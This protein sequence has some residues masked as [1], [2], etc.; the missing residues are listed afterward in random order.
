MYY[1]LYDSFL[2]DKKYSRLLGDIEARLIDLSIQGRSTKLNILNDIKE[3]ISDA[4]KQGAETVVVLGD[5]RTVSKAI[6]A[7]MHLDVV[8][9]IIPIGSNNYL[10]NYLGIPEGL[11]ACDVLSKRVKEN[12]DIAKVGAN[13]FAFYLKTLSPDI[14]IISADGSYSITPMSPSLSVYICNFRPD[15]IDVETDSNQHFFIP[16]DGRLELVIKSAGKSSFLNKLFSKGSSEFDQIG[17]YTIMP[18]KKIRIE[19]SKPNVDVKLSL[20]NDR[21]IKAPVEIEVLPKK[22]TLIV[23]KQRMF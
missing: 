3:L 2:Q 12:I 5:D 13:Y 10:A 19:S 7:V 9:G 11:G 1:Y 21:I 8:L 16:H 22:V 15:E 14:K 4:V 20:D 23:G 17:Q 6:S 18:F